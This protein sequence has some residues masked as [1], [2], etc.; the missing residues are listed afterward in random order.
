MK[1]IK[2]LVLGL[3]FG[4]GLLSTQTVEAADPKPQS[5]AK[6]EK[7][8]EKAAEKSEKPSEANGKAVPFQGT[9]SSVDPV[10]RTF[11][12]SGKT[13]DKDRVFKVAEGVQIL[14]GNEQ[15]SFK[16][17]AVG[18]LVRGQAY[19]R[20]DGWEAKKVMIGPKEEAPVK[21]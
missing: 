12:I 15:S 7:G 8:A 5:E 1:L 18:E 20:S 17:I 13:R 14:Q 3:L 19:K 10:A 6:E 16:A 2:L 21:R 9:V 11:T 4:G